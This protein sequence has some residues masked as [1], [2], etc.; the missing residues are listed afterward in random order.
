MTDETTAFFEALGRRG[1]EPML[2]R[3]TGT[4]RFDLVDGKRVHHWLVSIAR[5]EL[6]VA[7]DDLPADCVIRAE[8]SLFDDVA[9]GRMNAMAAALRGILS[10]EGDPAMLVRFQRLFP[11]PTGPPAGASDRTVGRRRG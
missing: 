8:R 5:G 10:L 6:V 4:M 11:A 1:R 9:S 7:A 2:G 3:T